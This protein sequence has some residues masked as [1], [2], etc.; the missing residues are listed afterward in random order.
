MWQRI[1]AKAYDLILRIPVIDDFIDRFRQRYLPGIVVRQVTNPED[2][3]LL[4]ALEEL[5]ES[6]PEDQRVEAA[7]Q[8][9]WI[10]E[11]NAP[12][13]WETTR[14]KDW[15]WV[16]RHRHRVRGFAVLHYYE[17]DY[18]G[19]IGY[20]VAART[21]GVP[22]YAISDALGRAMSKVLKR[23][24]SSCRGILLEVEDPRIAKNAKEQRERLARVARFCMLAQRQHLTLRALEIEYKQ[25]KLILGDKRPERPMLLLCAMI[26]RSLPERLP[27]AEVSKLLSFVYTRVY[28]DGYSAD[29]D[30]TA[31]YADYCRALLAREARAIPDSV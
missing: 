18:L 21:P 20:L 7:D 22:P 5:Y 27:R 14:S 19:F 12:K 31:A 23:A 8:I 25:P 10:G 16:A 17:P 9:R 30:E 4:P 6:I 26:R 28:P 13:N 29:T 1:L 11:S 3:D 2:P 15:F 24:L